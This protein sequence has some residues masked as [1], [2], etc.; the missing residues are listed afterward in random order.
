M[1]SCFNQTSRVKS[2][3]YTSKAVC[4]ANEK[5]QQAA[6]LSSEQHNQCQ[7]HEQI[8]VCSSVDQYH[9]THRETKVYLWFI[10]KPQSLSWFIHVIFL[11]HLS[12]QR[13]LFSIRF[14]H[15]EIRYFWSGLNPSFSI[16]CLFTHLTEEFLQSADIVFDWLWAKSKA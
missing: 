11:S 16:V 12:F 9:I 8:Q 4:T 6:D 14:I 3:R 5:S 15:G 13:V 10:T 2:P 7:Q 1:K